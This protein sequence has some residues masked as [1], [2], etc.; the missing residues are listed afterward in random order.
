MALL[1]T[2]QRMSDLYSLYPLDRKVAVLVQTVVFQ[3]PSKSNSE[4]LVPVET[5]M[6]LSLAHPLERKVAVLVQTE[7]R[8]LSHPLDSKMA[9]PAPVQT[10]MEMT[11]LYSLGPKMAV[12]VETVMRRLLHPLKLTFLVRG[13]TV[14]DLTVSHSLESKMALP[15]PAPKMM[16]LLLLH[17]LDMTLLVPPDPLTLPHY[18]EPN[19]AESK[20]VKPHYRSARLRQRQHGSLPC[21]SRERDS[22]W[23]RGDL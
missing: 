15:A 5:L 17:S 4:F 20:K 7:M 1:A 13:Q 10:V 11:L 22:R 8:R 12:L 6:D 21:L 9:L 19:K 14:M 16:D 3:H 18:L 2:I 23:Q